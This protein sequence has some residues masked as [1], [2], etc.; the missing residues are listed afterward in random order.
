MNDIKIMNGVYANFT[1]DQVKN[2][3]IIEDV[4]I[5][6]KI[7]VLYCPE[8]WNWQ[9]PKKFYLVLNRLP[10]FEEVISEF[11]KTRFPW[12]LYFSKKQNILFCLLYYPYFEE[13]ISLIE[14]KINSISRNRI[15][16]LKKYLF[17]WLSNPITKELIIDRN[18]LDLKAQEYYI[19]HDVYSK[20]QKAIEIINYYL[21]L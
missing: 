12:I 6:S 5:P 15:V 8:R 10:S 18:A 7:G 13:L 16:F 11:D 17:S 2:G 14:S 19:K 3:F 4:Y 21:S 20:S 1:I 9:D